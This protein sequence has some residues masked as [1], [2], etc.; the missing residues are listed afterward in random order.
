MYANRHVGLPHI[1]AHK[2]TP[3]ASVY[4]AHYA[5]LRVLSVASV[6]NTAP[7]KQ[8]QEITL[9]EQQGSH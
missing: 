6:P 4:D 9:H 3:A 5:H 2:H 1:L 7:T 8:T